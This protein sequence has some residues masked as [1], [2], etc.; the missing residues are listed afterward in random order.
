[1]LTVLE[2]RKRLEQL[3]PDFATGDATPVVPVKQDQVDTAIAYYQV[4]S[5]LYKHGDLKWRPDDGAKVEPLPAPAA[6]A[7]TATATAASVA[8]P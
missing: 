2:P 8:R 7:A 4:A 3:K 6:T 1:T 5:D